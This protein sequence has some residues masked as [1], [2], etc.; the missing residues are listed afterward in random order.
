MLRGALWGLAA[1]A[2]LATARAAAQPN[3]LFIVADDLGFN[4]VSFHGSPQIPTPHIDALARRGVTLNN[5]HAQPVCSPTRATILTGRHVIHTGVYTPFSQGTALR[6]GLAY[7]LLPAKLRALG[8]ATHMVGKWHLGQ[9][10]LAALPTRRGFDTYFG[11][12]SGAEDYFNHSC[13]GS[14]DLADGE[15]TAFEWNATYSA[16]LFARRAGE[17]V[18]AA[19]PAGAPWFLYLAFQNVHWP[20]EVP[21]RYLARVPPN[22]TGGN[23]DRRAIVAMALALDEG[24][25]NVSAALAAANATDNTLVVFVSD[26]GGPTNGHEDTQSNN[27][28]MRGGKNTLWEGGL[29]VVGVVA[30]AGLQPRVAGTV[31]YGLMHASDW[32]PTLVRAAAPPGRGRGGGA[33]AAAA[34]AEPPWQLGDGVDVWDMLASGA[35]SARTELLGEAHAPDAPDQVHGNALIVGDMKLVRL[36]RSDALDGNPPEEAGWHPPPGQDPSATA[37]QLRCDPA[38]PP[39]GGAADPSQCVDAWCLF[40]VTADPCEY[41]DVAAARPD[42]VAQLLARLAEYQATSVAPVGDDGCVPI[43]NAD[44]AWR[45]CDSPNSNGSAVGAVVVSV[46]PL[47]DALGI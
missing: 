27:Y 5:Y 21:A 31:N 42:A 8:Y 14:Y 40:N 26:N 47:N 13:K 1:L 46:G 10:E 35:P 25:G 34:A 15:A 37:Y 2:V 9:N 39:G 41:Y 38:G 7:E 43:V 18:R 28:P 16:P 30:G 33:A 44:N 45:P 29:R 20:L 17:L 22:A 4:D 3:I 6:L 24:V 19:D 32:L 12:W 11:Y 36:A 23:A